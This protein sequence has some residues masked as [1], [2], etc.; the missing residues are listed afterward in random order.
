MLPFFASIGMVGDWGDCRNCENCRNW[1]NCENCENWHNALARPVL[2]IETGFARPRHR[3]D[4]KN[5][6]PLKGQG[7][8]SYERSYSVVS[9]VLVTYLLV[10]H[11]SLR[12]NF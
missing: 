9:Y 4:Q 5:P 10:K 7:L 2:D 6:Q 1:R 12:T 3:K 8:E 11:C